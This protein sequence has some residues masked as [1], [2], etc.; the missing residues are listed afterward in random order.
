MQLLP[1]TCPLCEGEVIVQS[2]LCRSCD[3][4]LSGRFAIGAMSEFSPE[5][6]PVLRRFSRLSPE[7]LGLLEAFLRNEGKLNRVQ[8]E[9]GLSYPTLR[10][11][12][13]E[14]FDALGFAPRAAEPERPESGPQRREI[15]A[16]LQRGEISADEAAR[17]LRNARG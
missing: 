6:L 16:A 5:Q 1:T 9:M 7:Q 12:L 13:D 3:T 8:E 14:M 15:L 11:R 4:T 17:Q 2:L 10:A